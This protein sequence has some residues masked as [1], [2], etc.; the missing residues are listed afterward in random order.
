MGFK[1]TGFGTDMRE[2]GF[3]NDCQLLTTKAVKR[4]QSILNYCRGRTYRVTHYS[5][6]FLVAKYIL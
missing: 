6:M 3:G 4:A 5:I 2:P 1:K